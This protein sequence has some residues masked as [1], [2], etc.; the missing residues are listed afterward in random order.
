[1]KN[2][3]GKHLEQHL[4]AHELISAGMGPKHKSMVYLNPNEVV[5]M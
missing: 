3:D 5:F 2:E 4:E 1:M